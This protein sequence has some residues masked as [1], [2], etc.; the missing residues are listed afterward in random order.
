MAT[1]VCKEL[2]RYAK[3]KGDDFCGL[4][5]WC[6]MLLYADK[7]HRFCIVSACNV[8]RQAPLG[9][10][11]IFQQQLRYIQNHQLSTTPQ[12]LFMINFLAMLQVCCQQGDKLL[13]S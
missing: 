3:Q 11:T 6:F 13:S 12:R 8:G 2:A 10:S 5:H 1:L 4:G 9:N 7:N